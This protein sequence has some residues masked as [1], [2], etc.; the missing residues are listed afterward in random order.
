MNPGTEFYSN[1]REARRVLVI[2]P[3]MLGDTLHLLPAMRQLRYSYPQ[4]ELHVL[5]S[6]VGA[7]LHRMAGCASRLW[8]LPQG[9]QQRRLT[10][11]LRVLIGLRRLRFDA[12]INFGT[13][14]RNLIYAAIIG[15]R[16]RLGR[17]LD[18]WHFWSC[19]CV[20]DWVSVS[21]QGKP[22]FEER[23]L[24]LAAAGFPLEEARFSLAVP[25]EEKVWAAANVPAGALHFSINASTPVKEW[26]LRHWQELARLL[27]QEGGRPIIATG[28][29]HSREK[30]RLD[31]FAAA[32]PEARIFAGLP[33]KRLAALIER[34]SLHVG[35][36]SGVL[37]LALAVGTPTISL[38]RDYSGWQ[39]WAPQG[40]AHKVLSVHCECAGNKGVA[41]L[42]RKEAVCL[43][44]ISPE[45]V[46]SA[47]HEKLPLLVRDARA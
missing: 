32:V 4:A 43:A 37:H 34:C 17:R 22:A 30:Q 27:R 5:C 23:R 12:S 40:E 45:A 2:D 42:E 41:C 26:P 3:G 28:S 7:E 10:E 11:Q 36:D 21:G 24:M 19:W 18:R 16:R 25:A 35:A 29:N 31:A 1:T 47:I 9:R 20:P 46:L 6:P 39:I 44:G 14:D 15:A 13:N 38:F 8:V 33:L